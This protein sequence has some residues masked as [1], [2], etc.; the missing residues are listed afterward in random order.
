MNLCFYFFPGEKAYKHIYILHYFISKYVETIKTKN[1]FLC[2]GTAPYEF[3][4]LGCSPCIFLHHQCKGRLEIFQAA[5]QPESP[6]V[7][8]GGHLDPMA[9][10]TRGVFK[11]VRKHETFDMS[12]NFS[13]DS[14]RI[15]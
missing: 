8:R 4:G 5:L 6:R 9:K 10:K 13:S 3:L 2:F 1:P 7:D 14:C 15:P 12:V 11:K